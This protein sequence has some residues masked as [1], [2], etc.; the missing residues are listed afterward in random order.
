MPPLS[1]YPEA[2]RGR[3]Q[4]ALEELQIHDPKDGPKVSEA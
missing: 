3:I 2:Q 4:S 1:A